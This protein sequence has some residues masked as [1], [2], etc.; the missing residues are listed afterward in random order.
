[1]G[2]LNDKR[3]NIEIFHNNNTFIHY[4]M[5]DFFHH[6]E[7]EFLED[8]VTPSIIKQKAAIFLSH[9]GLGDNITNIGSVRFLLNYYTT[10][11]FLCKQQYQE[12][13]NLLF[14]N[15]SVVTIPIMASNETIEK[16]NCKMI[17]NNI[18]S[19]DI[20][21]FICGKG[22]TSYL[23]S[24]ITHPQLLS[25]QQDNKGFTCDYSH[26]HEFYY[27]IG[28]DFSIYFN[29]FNIP[30]SE[31]SLQYYQE[32]KKYSIVFLHTKAS[33]REINLDS[34]IKKYYND[35]KYIII[36]ANKNVYSL[37]H[38]YYSIAEKYVNIY[39]AY[40]IDIIKHAE[41]IQIIDSCFSCIVYPLMK[42]KLLRASEIK[43]VDR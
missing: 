40:Y 39:V 8:N 38:K 21:I 9:N 27:D 24:R 34:I 17:I 29:Y 25:Y 12:N 36:C 13:L 3:C 33:N 6:L 32:I 41:I 20:D 26:I 2:V 35:D 23:T 43:I 19:E 11:F 18:K 28:L 1:M 14:N 5:D 7:N 10:I 31:S 22:H 42:K 4:E 30:S 37:D 16:Q 15:D